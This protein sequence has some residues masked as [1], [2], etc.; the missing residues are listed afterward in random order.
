MNGLIRFHKSPYG[1]RVG[2]VMPTDFK[3]PFEWKHRADN[4][5]LIGS[6]I[7]KPRAGQY[8]LHPHKLIRDWR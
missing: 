3:P 5:T 4:L 8:C 7:R 1:W 2:F 6:F